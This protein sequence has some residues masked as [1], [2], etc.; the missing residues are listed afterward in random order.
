MLNDYTERLAEKEELRTFNQ[1]AVLEN[2]L[3]ALV[4]LLLSLFPPIVF[5]KQFHFI[6]V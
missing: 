6:I 4:V 5:V 2:I 3:L 1:A